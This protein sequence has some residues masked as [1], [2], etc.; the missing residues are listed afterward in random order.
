M[1]IILS[2]NSST[3]NSPSFP[4]VPTSNTAYTITM[5]SPLLCCLIFLFPLFSLAYEGPRGT[6]CDGTTY[7]AP[8]STFSSNLDTALQILQNTTASSG[9][10]TTT[11][12][13]IN[14]TVTALALCRATINPSDCQLC[15]DVATSGSRNVCPN[16]TAAQV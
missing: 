6:S 14:Q 13:S 8:N 1:P 4:V 16:G 9:F 2:L 11:S 15:I 7:Y 12:G 5:F 10:A 3:Y